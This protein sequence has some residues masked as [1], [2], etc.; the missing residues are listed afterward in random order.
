M[1]LKVPNNLIN[2]IKVYVEKQ[3]ACALFEFLVLSH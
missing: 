3:A 1:D 2:Y